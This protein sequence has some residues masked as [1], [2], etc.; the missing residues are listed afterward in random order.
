ML[1]LLLI[2]SVSGQDCSVCCSTLK[3]RSPLFYTYY[4]DTGRL[5]G[6]ENEFAIE[7]FGYSGMNTQTINGRNNPEAQC[8]SNTGPAPATLY[9]LGTCRDYMHGTTIRPC[10]FPMIP[11]NET[12]MCGRFAML[13]HGCECCSESN[14]TC[15]FSV[16]PC[17]ECSQGC[18]VIS[19]TERVKLRTG[20]YINVVSYDPK[21]DFL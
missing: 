21:P 8:I 14:P 18:I 12:Q 6:G 17:G 13:I 10:S 5:V 3:P 16:P 2:S 7:T 9:E 15:D 20:D 1:Y 4:Q 19:K 11:L